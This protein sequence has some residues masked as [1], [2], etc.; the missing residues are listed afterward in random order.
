MV[1]PVTLFADLFG[2]QLPGIEGI[3]KKCCPGTAS[4]K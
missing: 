2:V 3:D 1:P 4:M